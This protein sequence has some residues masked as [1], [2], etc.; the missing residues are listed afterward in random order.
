MA[1]STSTPDDTTARATMKSYY[2]SGLF[3]FNSFELLR[4]AGAGRT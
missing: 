1:R 2:E 4:L 3:L